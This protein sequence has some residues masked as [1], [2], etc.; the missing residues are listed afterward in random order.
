MSQTVTTAAQGLLGPAPILRLVSIRKSFGPTRAVRD[1]SFEVRPGEVH[2]LMGE[3]GS[4]KSTL[5]KILSGVHQ[6]DGGTIVVGGLERPAFDSPQDA[7]A[8]GV[9]TV[10][11]EV[12]A[13]PNRTVYDNLWLGADGVFRVSQSRAERRRLAADVLAELLDAPPGLDELVGDLALSDRQACAIARA[14][15]R[16]PRLLVL[17]EAT[18]ALDFE[19]RTRLFAMVAR[20]VAAGAGA[21]LITHR[22][23]EVR[24][25]ADRVTVLRAGE[26]VGTMAGDAWTTEELVQLM[27]GHDHLVAA[28]DAPEVR[29]RSAGGVV[30]QAVG[31]RAKRDSAP[32]DFTLRAGEIVGLAGLEG[33]GQ[34]RFLR[35]LAGRGSGQGVVERVVTGRRTGIASAAAARRAGIAYVPRDRRDESL[36]DWMPIVENFSTA[37]L[38]TDRRGGLLSARAALERFAKYVGLLRIKLGKPSDGITTL[39][40]G[41]QQKVIIARWLAAEPR[42]LLLNDPTRGIDI[43]A[44]RDLYALLADLAADGLAVVMLST[45]VDEHLELMDRVLVFRDDAI[46][47]E[48]TH[49]E[50]RRD[51]LVASFFGDRE[52]RA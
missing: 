14:V 21:I 31:V 45:E 27:T 30:L 23:D 17:D 20:R 3:N 34:D 4:G 10:F 5:V 2:A 33:Q 7:L 39:S 50:I 12:L 22:M 18:S 11:Q 8:S 32:I 47:A 46:A 43:G 19:T 49:A 6:P 48:F 35:A 16:E 37:T 13:V 40:G 24:E 29:P 9:A 28:D 44:K 52:I 42:I 51:G 15:L 25:I 41:N 1:A 26:T 36:F 38:A